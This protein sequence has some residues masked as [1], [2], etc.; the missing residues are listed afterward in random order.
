MPEQHDPI[1]ELA[2]FGAGFGA[3]NPGGDMPLSAADVR[4]RGDQIR[5]RRTALVAGGAALAAAAVS[6]P[7]FAVIGGDADRN[8]DHVAGD[9]DGGSSVIS[10]A[11]LLSD[12]ETVY[13]DGADWFATDTF[14]G[15]GDDPFQMCA[16]ESLTDLGAT[17]VVQRDFELRNAQLEEGET[18]PEV[19]GDRF[20]EAIAQFP[21]VATASAAYDTIA[22][23]IRDC[24]E[25]ATA[26]GTPEYRYNQAYDADTGLGGDSEAVILDS[27]YGPVPD[28][29]LDEAYLAETGLV[30][31]GD[32]IAVLDSRIVGQDYNFLPEEGGT[33]VNQMIPP[34][35]SLLATAQAD[36]GQTDGAEGDGQDGDG[37][38]G[39]GQA[40]GDVRIPD[41]YPLASG[42]PEPG[43]AES[44]NGLTGPERGLDPLAFSACGTDQPDLDHADR[45]TARWEDVEDYRTRQLTVYATVAEATAMT[46]ALRDLYSGCPV[47]EV[48]EDGYTPNWKVEDLGAGDGSFAVL[49]WDELDGSPS[50]FGETIVVV[51]TGTA[52]LVEARAG[53]GGNPQGR[54]TEVI[55]QV[56]TDASDVVDGLCAFRAAGC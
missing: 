50:T 53:H 54:E 31:V 41:G 36:P 46:T 44:G 9:P 27:Q 7:V 4:R 23:W 52:V 13:N 14:V 1:D 43:T 49:G 39:D 5:R 20:R 17:A 48:R 16:R 22:E 21:D 45:L 11:N 28:A 30:R 19:T 2:R 10:E 56:L 51:R 38:D 3:A 33:P 47:E 35:A 37:Q 18:P 40:A 24:T 15:D 12:A 34:A 8:G 55:E 25:A 42:W 6:V 26:A 29:E 32:R